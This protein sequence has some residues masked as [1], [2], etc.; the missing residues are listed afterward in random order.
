M[1]NFLNNIEDKESFKEMVK[2]ALN[3]QAFQH[4]EDLKKEMANEFLTAEEDQ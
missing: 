4:L 2:S 3:Q 1:E